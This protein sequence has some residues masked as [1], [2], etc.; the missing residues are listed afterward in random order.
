MLTISVENGAEISA[1]AEW[2]ANEA[3]VSGDALITR[4][5]CVEGGGEGAKSEKQSTPEG[6]I[7]ERLALR[8]GAQPGF[9][10][11][12]VRSRLVES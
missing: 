1:I 2:S 11:F 12:I 3:E 8:I 9:G 5:D 7:H 4:T 6:M 10:L